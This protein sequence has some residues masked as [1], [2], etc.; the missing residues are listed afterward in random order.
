MSAI[1]TAIIGTAAV[2]GGS[3]LS[4]NAKTSAVHGASDIAANQQVQDQ[5]RYDK[6]QAD[7]APYKEFGAQGL[8]QAQNFDLMGGVGPAVSYD[9]EYTN[10]LGDYQTSPAFK[11]Q[12]NIAQEQLARSSHARGLDTGRN[13]ANAQADV[14]QR[15]VATDYDKYRGDLAQRYKA[16]QGEYG[17]RRENNQ[18][19]YKQLMDQ[20]GVG[21]KALGMQADNNNSFANQSSKNTGNMAGAETTAGNAQGD[22]WQ[23]IGN[24]VGQGVGFAGGKMGGLGNAAAGSSSMFD[25]SQGLNGQGQ[26]IQPGPLLSNQGYTYSGATFGGTK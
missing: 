19:R 9:T 14:T 6:Q 10:K 18:N 21:Q 3:M 23:N 16:L 2:V 22:M 8:G 4:A 24:A 25:S 12:D 1:A 15:L 7:I 26:P 5:M 11:A 20:V 13:A 17:L